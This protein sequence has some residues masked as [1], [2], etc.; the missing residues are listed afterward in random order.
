MYKN[1]LQTIEGIGIYPLIS[2]LIFQAVFLVVVIW[3]FRADKNYLLHM[4]RLP[5]DQNQSRKDQDEETY[6]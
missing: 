5:L 4:S 3:F 6:T 1:V 2:M